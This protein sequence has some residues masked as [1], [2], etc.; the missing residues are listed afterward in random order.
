MST[1]DRAVLRSALVG[2]EVD[3]SRCRVESRED[4]VVVLVPPGAVTGNLVDVLPGRLIAAGRGDDGM[5][6]VIPVAEWVEDSSAVGYASRIV[7]C[8]KKSARRSPGGLDVF[9]T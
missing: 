8:H 2:A 5:R 1:V 9:V 7:D 6:L 3:W 4:R